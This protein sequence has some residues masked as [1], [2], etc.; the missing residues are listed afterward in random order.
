MILWRWQQVRRKA[1]Q[2]KNHAQV[3]LTRGWP[4]EKRKKKTKRGA[5][6]WN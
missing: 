2:P 6:G 4:K 3:G 5:S 1:D